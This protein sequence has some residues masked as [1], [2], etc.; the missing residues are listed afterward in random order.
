MSD[1]VSD[2]FAKECRTMKATIT[3]IA[4]LLVMAC[5]VTLVQA[6]S[7]PIENT[8]TSPVL[9]SPLQTPASSLEREFQSPLATPIFRI[10][11]VGKELVLTQEAQYVL[12]VA[13]TRS[14]VATLTWTP[15]FTVTLTPS[16]MS[17]QHPVSI[18]TPLSP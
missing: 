11:Y 16:P 14:A 12:E 17:S 9:I 7:V 5:A 2:I 10:N 3:T 8:L 4:L 15:T 13:A 18:A 1:R 6:V